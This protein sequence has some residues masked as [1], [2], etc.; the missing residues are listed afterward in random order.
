MNNA[1]QMGDVKTLLAPCLNWEA[2]LRSMF[3]L[4]EVFH[5][6]PL[7]LKLEVG[8]K[9]LHEQRSPVIDLCERKQVQSRC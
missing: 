8:L 3:L 7:W 6:T 2:V 5:W 4:I 9:V 1:T